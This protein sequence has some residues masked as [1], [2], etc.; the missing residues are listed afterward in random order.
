MMITNLWSR[1]PIFVIAAFHQAD[2]VNFDTI[3][4]ALERMVAS[5][6]LFET[7]NFQVSADFCMSCGPKLVLG[8]EGPC[9]TKC[10]HRLAKRAS[11][12]TTF[13]KLAIA[14]LIATSEN[15]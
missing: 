10:L 2:Y 1:K 4:Q 7:E 5:E 8:A 11:S 9:L 13:F 15:G 6:F 14:G 12:E 3:L